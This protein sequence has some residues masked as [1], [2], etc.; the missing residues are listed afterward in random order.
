MV[1]EVF[2]R[3]LNSLCASRRGHH[4]PSSPSSP[5]PPPPK[6]TPLTYP[7]YLLRLAYLPYL[8]MTGPGAYICYVSR[9]QIQTGNTNGYIFL[10]TKQISMHDARLKL[11]HVLEAP[12][13]HDRHSTLVALQ[14]CLGVSTV[15]EVERYSLSPCYPPPQS[16]PLSPTE[17]Y[18]LQS[19]ILVVSI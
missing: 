4:P 10:C 7:L 18:T 11:A 1:Y 13:L 8:P 16:S 12:F 17:L 9:R 15:S 6:K 14:E 2:T 19:L 3:L 5:H